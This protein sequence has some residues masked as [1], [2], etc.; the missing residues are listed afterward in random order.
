MRGRIASHVRQ[1][2]KRGRVRVKIVQNGMYCTRHGATD[3]RLKERNL[4]LKKEEIQRGFPFL[5]T[6]GKVQGVYMNEEMNMHKI[7]DCLTLGVT[8]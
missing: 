1:D 4:Q 7:R 5:S 2:K 3:A 6:W 8:C